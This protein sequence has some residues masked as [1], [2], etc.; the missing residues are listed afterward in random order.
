MFTPPERILA[1]AVARPPFRFSNDS[2]A[3]WTVAIKSST[4]TAYRSDIVETIFTFHVV[5]IWVGT[6]FWNSVSNSRNGRNIVITNGDDIVGGG[7]FVIRYVAAT[8]FTAPKGAEHLVV[9]ILTINSFHPW[10]MTGPI[11]SDASVMMSVTNCF[12][13]VVDGSLITV[14]CST[15]SLDDVF[16]NASQTAVT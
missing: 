9:N 15:S 7:R 6:R 11:C 2:S 12:V 10:S 1:A 13:S 8:P 16:S 4:A 5:P 14:S 3:R